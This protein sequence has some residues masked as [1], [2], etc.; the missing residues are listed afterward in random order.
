MYFVLEL[1]GRC[2]WCY[3]PKQRKITLK[4]MLVGFQ[5][6]FEF[7]FDFDFELPTTMTLPMTMNDGAVVVLVAKMSNRLVWRSSLLLINFLL[8]VILLLLLLLLLLLVEEK[9]AFV[10]SSLSLNNKH[11]DN[12][13]NCNH[14]VWIFWF[15]R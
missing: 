10:S 15:R 7:D 9:I 5:F 8:I 13:D 12:N 4:R 14:A 2:C 3:R 6:Q 11:K 1:F